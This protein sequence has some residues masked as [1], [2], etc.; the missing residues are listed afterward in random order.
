VLWISLLRVQGRP[1]RVC[2]T[3]SLTESLRQNRGI[4]EESVRT[5]LDGMFA[6]V[7][8]TYIEI[9][10]KYLR[11][12]K[13][14]LFRKTIPIANIH[15]L[16]YSTLFAGLYPGTD[17]HYGNRSGQ[18]GVGAIPGF[19]PLRKSDFFISVQMYSN[20][21]VSLQFG[22]FFERPWYRF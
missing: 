22:F 19:R 12:V 16:R 10:E 18:G 3:P 1:H 20:V 4:R 11:I 9:D 14:L 8:Y 5:A 21:K 17:V 13:I 6:S 7:F 15:S 2:L